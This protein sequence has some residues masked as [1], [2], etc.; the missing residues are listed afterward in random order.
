M[1]EDLDDRKMFV[2]FIARLAIQPQGFRILRHTK[3]VLSTSNQSSCGFNLATPCH[4]QPNNAVALGQAHVT[5]R[6][7]GAPR[8]LDNILEALKKELV[9]TT[10]L[11]F[12]DGN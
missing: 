9:F 1:I 4:Q 6:S 7:V 5:E 11:E 12:L 3:D 2:R 8:D 10:C